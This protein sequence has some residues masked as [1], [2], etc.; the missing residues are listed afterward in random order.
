MQ[1]RIIGRHNE[2]QLLAKYMQTPRSEFIAVYGRR[3]V[4]K[5]FLVRHAI[6]K[7]ACFSV[8]GMENVLLDE[9]LANFYISLR[10]VYPSAVRCGSWL[11]AFDQLEQYLESLQEGN[12]ILFFD[13][14]PWFD[15]PR[16][17]FVS[18]L[19]HFW[20]N[21]ASARSDI[22]LVTCGSA[23]SWMLDHLINNHGGLHNRVTHQMLIEPFSLKECKEYFDAYDFGYQVREVAEY[24]MVF[25]GVPYYL[26][27]MNR[28]ESVAQNVDRLI[29]SATGEL[30]AERTNLFRS[31]FK[32][33]ADYVTIV[34]AL[35]AKR[36]GLTRKELLDATRLDNNQRFST[37]LQELENCRFIRQYLP[38][39]DKKRDITY[40]LIDPFLHFS[41]QVQAKCK[42]QDENYWSHS[43]NSPIYNAW[44]GFA[45]EMLCLNHVPQIKAALKIEGVQTSVY[46]WR[47]PAQAERG[48]QIDLLIDR[49]DHCV[50]LCEMKFCRGK[51]TITKAEREKIENRMQS[52]ITHSKTKSSIRLTMITSFGVE[53]NTNSGIIQ[54]E[55]TLED[56][57]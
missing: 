5:T 46:C 56:L 36:K 48:A 38:Y 44:S 22:K 6:G 11:E 20:N 2:L 7:E 32:R 55:L 13:E 52:F 21:W 9:Q 4:G 12:K 17:N 35:S 41:L 25:G 31:L 43:I 49:A 8:T 57:F 16:S 24:Y 54:N 19:E 42:Y 18:A 50:N 33:S 47:T 15:T 27:L 39:S 34:E 28:D 26:S 30:S 53:K 1:E 14:L 23:A 29:F 3:R 45:F 40:Q 37:M 51:Y 10:K